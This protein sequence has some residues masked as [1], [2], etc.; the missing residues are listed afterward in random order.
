[1]KTEMSENLMPEV[2]SVTNSEFAILATL[3]N[4]PSAFDECDKLLPEHFVTAWL[5]AVYIEMRSQ[6]AINKNFD[7]ISLSERLKGVATIA[8]LHEIETC[9]IS[10]RRHI[11]FHIGRLITAS[12]SRKLYELSGVLQQMAFETT[13]IQERID[14]AST[15]LMA[16]EDAE[17]Y[18]EWVGADESAIKHLDLIEARERGINLGM[19]TGLQDFDE[20]LDGG[21]QRGNLVVIGSRPSVGKS[22]LALTIGLSMAQDYHVGFVSM[23]MSRADVADRQI[24]I[25]GSIPISH[26]KRPSKGLQYDRVVEAVEKS[27]ARKFWIVEQGGLN[28]FQ[29][30]SK[31]KALKRRQGLD[32]LI[33]D[34]IGLMSGTDT[35][36][37]RAYQI[38]EISRSLKTLAKELDIVIIC[39]AQVNRGAADK[40]N[41][42]PSLHELRDSGSIEQDADVVGFIHRP[43]VSDP[44]LEGDWQNYAVLRIAKNRQGR[45]ADLHL[46]YAGEQTKFSQWSGQVPQKLSKSKGGL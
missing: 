18:G 19:S 40:G 3:M 9:Y 29:V 7:V 1:M 32:V 33:I 42:P 21:L 41:I 13:P 14:R 5:Q 38:E 16:L 30:R 22:A 35:K 36:V 23:E 44:T 25:L 8:E 11:S 27:R 43:I 46:F 26:I 45:C 34:Y 28:I 10:G 37:S 15:A 4:H 39:L 6:L 12:K 24:A 31:A 2:D 17:D 20:L